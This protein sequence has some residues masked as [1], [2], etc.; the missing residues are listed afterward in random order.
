M[1]L[2]G[3]EPRSRPE[4]RSLVPLLRNPGAGW[5]STAITAFGDRN[6]SLRTER[7]RYIRYR[8]LQEELYDCAADPNEWR[9]Q[10]A[11]PAY[12]AVLAE[13]RAVVPPLAQMVRSLPAKRGGREE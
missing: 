9:N 12:A 2:C 1:E 5:A 8:D 3:L 11:N 13:L 4:G 6:V 10:A 7:H